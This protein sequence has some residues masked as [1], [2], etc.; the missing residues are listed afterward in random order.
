[1][2]LGCMQM[3][4]IKEVQLANM[5]HSKYTCRTPN[6]TCITASGLS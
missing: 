4:G 2:N 3:G 5:Q 6:S 1:M